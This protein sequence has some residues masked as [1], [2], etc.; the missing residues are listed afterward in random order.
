MIW[1]G[2]HYDIIKM[3]FKAKVLVSIQLETAV[4][5]FILKLNA[6]LQIEWISLDTRPWQLWAGKQIKKF[7]FEFEVVQMR[8]F[9]TFTLKTVQL[10]CNSP[11][12]FIEIRCCFKWKLTNSNFE[13]WIQNTRFVLKLDTWMNAIYT[14]TP[15]WSFEI[16]WNVHHFSSEFRVS[17]DTL[18]LLQIA[19]A[20]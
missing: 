10:L 9:N 5:S 16:F 15:I 13:N 17:H 6:S 4:R 14:W 7:F 11:F 8:K 18:W 1:N 19:N 20:F 2:N 3:D 12:A